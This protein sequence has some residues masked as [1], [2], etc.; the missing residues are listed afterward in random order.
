MEKS[1]IK[2]ERQNIL[3]IGGAGF[4]G[5]QLCE[6]LLEKN[7]VIC[8]DDYS[9]GKESNIDRLLSHQNFEFVRHDITEA[10]DFKNFPGVEKFRMAFIGVHQVYYLADFHSPRYALASPLE[11]LILATA[12][13]KNAMDIA[14]AYSA[15]CIFISDADVYGE[16]AGD[17]MKVH[18]DAVGTLDYLSLVNYHGHAKRIGESIAMLY[19]KQKKVR[20]SI[21]RLYTTYGPH[22]HLDDGRLIPDMVARALAGKEIV[23]TPGMGAATF[24]YVTDAIDALEKVMA[25]EMLGIFNIGNPTQYSVQEAAER[26]VKFCGSRSPIVRREANAEEVLTYRAWE[27][28]CRIANIDTLRDATGWFPVVLLDEGLRKTIDYMKSLRAIRG[29]FEKE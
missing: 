5:S 28:S 14:A 17:P 23:L 29:V 25:A 15:K 16:V 22:M 10:L 4:L 19:Q 21:A 9:C 11:T 6:Y 2:F 1:K 13:T 27:Q 26:I 7:N 8:V 12:G 3:V 24:L 18:E 20:V